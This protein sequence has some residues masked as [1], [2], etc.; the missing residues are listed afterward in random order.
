MSTDSKN[1]T[2]G[3]FAKLAQL[4]LTVV[5][6]GDLASLWG[7]ENDNLL[8][9]TVSRYARA[10]LL[11]RL[12]KGCYAIKDPQ[13]IDPWF[14]GIGVLHRYAYVSTETILAEA[15]VI[16]QYIPATT[17]VSN[18]SRRFQVRGHE[19]AVRQLQPKYLANTEGIEDRQGIYVARPERAAADLWYFNPKAYIDNLKALDL[20]EV[21]RIRRAVGYPQHTQANI[22]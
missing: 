14:L 22:T 17:I 5:H 21:E 12:Q 15:G 20:D 2:Q 1:V 4:G 9:T 10:G 8:Y 19:F 7:I 11:F 3:R 18:A 13:T 6:V 16:M